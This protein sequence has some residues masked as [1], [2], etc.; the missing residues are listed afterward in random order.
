[1]EK[2]FSHE[3]DANR[4]VLRI[5]GELTAVVDYVARGES[6]SFTHTFTNPTRR[7]QGY[8]GEI[9]GFAVDDVERTSTRHII[10]MCWYVEQWFDRHPDRATLLAPRTVSEASLPD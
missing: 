4:Y 3:P 6:I 5:D 10:P 8:A 1:M 7:G 2:T 9:V